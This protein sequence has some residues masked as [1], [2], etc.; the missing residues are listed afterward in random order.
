[1]STLVEIARE[2]RRWVV[3][4]RD[5]VCAVEGHAI[6]TEEVAVGKTKLVYWEC[7]KCGAAAMRWE[8]E[9]RVIAVV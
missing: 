6:V 1:M 3:R 5:S 7:Q 4:Q 9:G 2:V 8:K